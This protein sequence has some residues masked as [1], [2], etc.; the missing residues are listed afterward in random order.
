MRSPELREPRTGPL[1]GPAGRPPRSPPRSSSGGWPRRADREAPGRPA[2]GT[3]P[4]PSAEFI[5]VSAERVHE[6]HLELLTA[7][8]RGDGRGDGPDNRRG[9]GRGCPAGVGAGAGT[10]AASHR[11]IR[12]V[13][14]GNRC[15][16]ADYVGFLANRSVA[17]RNSLRTGLGLAL[18]V[19]VTH[20]FPVEH[21]FW[22]V[23]GAMSVLRSSALT[24]GTRWCGP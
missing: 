2:S 15:G 9:R 21:G 12:P 22:V 19:A 14:P 4:G 7:H 3:S 20:L 17:V 5:D 11:R 23:L 1:T 10:A 16:G 6:E 24:T 8:H 18:A 13:A